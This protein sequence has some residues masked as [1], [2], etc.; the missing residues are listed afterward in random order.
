MLA[1]FE[2]TIGQQDGGTIEDLRL[3]AILFSYDFRFRMGPSQRYVNGPDDLNAISELERAARMEPYSP[4]V[5]AGL[6][7]HYLRV[8]DR[9]NAEKWFRRGYEISPNSAFMKALLSQRRD[10]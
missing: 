3:A 4:S 6:M 9:N 2:H 7:L 8:G 5:A 10:P 1:E